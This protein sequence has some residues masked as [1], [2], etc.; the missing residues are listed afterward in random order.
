MNLYTIP[1]SRSVKQILIMI[2]DALM[3]VL[4]LMFSFILL[5]KDFFDQDQRF[6]FYLSLATTCLLYTSDAADE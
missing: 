5:G 4:A 6:Y 3:I 2:A 1:L